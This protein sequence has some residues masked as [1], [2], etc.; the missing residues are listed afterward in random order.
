[1]SSA[2][3]YPFAGSRAIWL[4]GAAAAFLAAV[5]LSRWLGP[6]LL[7]DRDPG[8]AGPRLALGLALCAAAAGAGAL[9]AGLYARWSRTPVAREPLRAIPWSGGAIRALTLA[10]LAAGLLLRVF[11]WSHVRV[12]Y[13]ED[14]VN[15]VGPSLS[16]SG[17]AR[18]FADSIRPIPYG[19]PDPHEMIG[20]IYLRALRSIMSRVGPTPEA[21][22][23]PSLV[24]GAASLVTAGL[25]AR[26][27]LPAG[28]G[29]LAVLALA[30]LRWHLILSISGWHSV[31][32]VPLVD[33]AALGLVA[34]R[35]R[36]AWPPALAGGAALGIGT[37]LYLASWIAA[38]ALLVYSVW[39]AEAARRGR[40]VRALAFA[41][42][43]ALVASPLF[44][45]H[46][47]R[48]RPY[49]GRST[50]H[51][52]LRE[53][54]YQ[55]SWLPAFS[56][57]ADA[58]PAPWLI[59]D[60]EGRHDL[61][62]AS[63][64]GWIVGIPV[65]VALARA[66]RS[67]REELSG[68]LIAHGA[69]GAAAAVASGTAGHP[70]G[71]RFG[72]LSSLTAVAASAGLLAL[73]GAAPL[74][75]RRAAAA[76]AVALLALAGAVGVRQAYV[77]WPSRRATFD[78]FRG[79]DTL[80]GAAAARWD[81]Y[82]AVSVAPGLGRSDATI[83]TVRRWGLWPDGAGAPDPSGPRRRTLRIV[84]T[85]AS[86][87]PDERVVESVRD[88]FGREWAVVLAKPTSGPA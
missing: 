15:L 49:F 23:F 56:A 29:A 69:F 4:V 67:P 88:A 51:N 77:A 85:R 57:A 22:R 19:R 48:T 83:E 33:L 44:L 37:H 21:V 26:A 54:A 16:L 87:A 68:L 60:P 14:E 7:L 40:L 84:K 5:D 42:G 47:G 61:E 64:L 79:E 72:Y 35:R 71:F 59:P 43:F 24:G 86:R 12:P 34:A 1:M 18:D 9:A 52:L 41:A 66:L 28:G 78:S 50:R 75:R 53:V 17:T 8:W 3:A 63:R 38:A 70:N 27:L 11:A 62:G 58:L 73:V 80:I 76:I 32:L 74:A 13:L 39:P 20:V 31:L 45:F 36:G 10:A 30:G 6:A 81:R 82:G 65:A 2:R 25:L 55:K 46:E